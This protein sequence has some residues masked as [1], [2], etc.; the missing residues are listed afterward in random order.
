VRSGRCGQR[1]GCHRLTGKVSRRRSEQSASTCSDTCSRLVRSWTPWS[2]CPVTVVRDTIP[3]R[4][5]RLAALLLA[6]M[7]PVSPRVAPCDPG[8][9]DALRRVLSTG[10]IMDSIQPG[11]DRV[12]SQTS[13]SRV[14]RAV[15]IR[16]RC[17][18]D[19]GARSTRMT[20][21]VSVVYS[22][23]F[24]VELGPAARNESQFPRTAHEVEITGA[25][26]SG[27]SLR[28]GC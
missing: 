3:G 7:L 20:L 8:R 17:A 12:P 26:T 15:P 16:M 4:A 10:Q 28:D 6:Q 18:G 13:A 14:R 5:S 25:A 1:A 27:Q 21:R 23:R 19:I 9:R 11:L 24:P 22:E 2:Y